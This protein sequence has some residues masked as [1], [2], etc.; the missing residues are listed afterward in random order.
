M[1]VISDFNAKTKK[2]S[3]MFI[4]RKP[5]PQR[6]DSLEAA[7]AGLCFWLEP[8]GWWTPWQ[9][10]CPSWRGLGTA[11]PCDKRL[12]TA[13]AMF[14]FPPFKPPEPE[15][16]GVFPNG[17]ALIAGDYYLSKQPWFLCSFPKQKTKDE[18]II[19][20]HSL[21][22]KIIHFYCDICQYNKVLIAPE[23]KIWIKI[24]FYYL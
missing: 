8:K 1:H 2:K 6:H 4:R 7:I 21:L 11:Q 18:H 16:R 22:S 17:M 23:K 24:D 3:I 20:P 10:K 13:S 5:H 12:C 15:G 19:T 9:Y 14:T